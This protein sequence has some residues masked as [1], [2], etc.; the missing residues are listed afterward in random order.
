M[1]KGS[2]FAWVKISFSMFIGSTLNQ[3]TKRNSFW[4]R[5]NFFFFL[6]FQITFNNATRI[7]IRTSESF[8]RGKFYFMSSQLLRSASVRCHLVTVLYPVCSELLP[9]PSMSW[10]LLLL[11]PW[12]PLTAQLGLGAASP[13]LVESSVCSSWGAPPDESLFEDGDVILG[14]L[15]PIH[16]AESREQHSFTAK[17]L[18][19]PCT[20]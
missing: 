15:F 13:G 19:K 9:L 17:P 6:T 2:R 5:C 4:N 10:F 12:S 16:Y 14:G 8:A 7:G 3:L 20:G 11:T 1:H 18:Y